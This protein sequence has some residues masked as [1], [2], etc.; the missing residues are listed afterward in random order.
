MFYND[1]IIASKVLGLTLT[2]RNKE[3]GVDVPMCGFPHMHVN[4]YVNKLVSNGY[5]VAI[6]DQV[7]DPN[8]SKG[9]M[10]RE[11]VK[12]VTPG[13]VI[14]IE[15]LEANNNNFIASI[16]VEQN[17]AYVSYIDITT[18]VFNA[19]I[20]EL[21][22]I[23]SLIYMLD[24]KEL[25][26]TKQSYLKLKDILDVL[27]ISISYVEKSK[28]S[29]EF[30]SEYFEISSLDSF[31]LKD[32]ILIDVCSTLLEYI[33]ETQVKIN[34][35]ITKISVINN[36]NYADININTAKNLE[37]FKNQRDKTSYGTLL[38]VLDKC[39]TSMGSRKLKQFLN[40]PLMDVEKINKRYDD[41]QYLIDNP[42]LKEELKEAL[43]NVFDLERILSKIVFGTQNAKDLRA[44]EQTFVSYL[45]IYSLWEDKFKSIDVE[46]LNN[47][48]DEINRYI[49]ADPPI[50][51]RDGK[52]INI[53]F[54]DDTKELNEII[55]HGREYILNIEQ[56][57]KEKL[58]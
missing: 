30:L 3:K 29:V 41:V 21:D 47:L 56:E 35:N 25:V 22:K 42:L 13:T 10:T 4:T 52:M 36:E 8:N 14:D 26:L 16:F 6:C 34:L 15:N 57:L 27:D 9:I 43:E 5:K 24:F 20:V 53:D 32:K 54:N 7:V 31:G 17:K 11:V 49:V 48:I 40:Y 23:S 19:C 45:K 28:N 51:V 33:L 37:L 39:K 18:S 50:S 46:V 44:L 2:K 38:W 1:A 55:N 58:E 12:V